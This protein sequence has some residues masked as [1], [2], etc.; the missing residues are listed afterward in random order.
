MVILSINLTTNY[1]QQFSMW[2]LPFSWV[3]LTKKKYADDATLYSVNETKKSITNELKKL[4][5]VIFKM[6]DNIYSKIKR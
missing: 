4:S 3:T 1:I 5:V 6:L 2:P